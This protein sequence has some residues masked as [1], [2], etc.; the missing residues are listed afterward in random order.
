MSPRLVR[1]L[2]VEGGDRSGAVLDRD[3]FE[4]TQAGGVAAASMSEHVVGV[5]LGTQAVAAA[6]GHSVGSVGITWTRDLDTEG[7]L[8]L[9]ALT[10]LGINH[11][12]AVPMLDAAE[13]L[14]C[15][16]AEQVGGRRIASLIV[17]SDSAVASTVSSGSDGVSTV[18]SQVYR[19]RFA[20]G[21]SLGNLVESMISNLLDEPEALFLADSS[22]DVDWIAGQLDGVSHLPVIG[23]EAEFGLA[24]G[25]AIAARR[26]TPGSTYSTAECTEGPT[27]EKAAEPQSD[28]AA[29]P[30]LFVPRTARLATLETAPESEPAE[31]LFATPSN[32]RAVT[33]ARVLTAVVIVASATLLV[34]LT[35]AFTDEPGRVDS[36]SLTEAQSRQSVE[37]PPE[38]PPNTQ[39]YDPELGQGA[40]PRV[41]MFSAPA[42]TSSSPEPSTSAAPG[43]TSTVTAP[44]K[45]SALPDIF[46]PLLS[47][48]NG[49]PGIP[50][51]PNTSA[52]QSGLPA[53]SPFDAA[54]GTDPLVVV[55]YQPFT[56]A[57]PDPAKIPI[58]DLNPGPAPTVLSGIDGLLVPKT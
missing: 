51:G 39:P 28:N 34:S 7:W 20:S 56:L 52:A 2:L 46:G 5:V 13:A 3:E 38:L 45:S 6:R 49:I 53:R 30:S 33:L 43:R 48:F 36:P 9:E 40:E 55:M 29:L 22:G 58:P 25:A 35:L 31:A 44:A 10:S 12:V 1:L 17:E 47:L 54:V 23:A 4:V 8:V 16:L 27:P 42:L 37:S 18:I 41:Q 11:A 50:G 26:R 32:R 24:R 21:E 57:I 15:M 19:G 14:A